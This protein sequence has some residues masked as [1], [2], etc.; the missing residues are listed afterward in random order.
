MFLSLGEWE[1]YSWKFLSSTTSSFLLYMNIL[2][3]IFF[4]I[5]SFY[6]LNHNALG[7]ESFSR[8]S[9]KTSL[10][11]VSKLWSSKVK[12]NY[13]YFRH[14]L[15]SRIVRF[16]IKIF[17]AM[18]FKWFHE[19]HPTVVSLPSKHSLAVIFVAK[20]WF[21]KRYQSAKNMV[22]ILLL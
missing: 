16:I 15:C 7:Y 12:N 21:N 18:M 4:T 10:I 20:L 1:Y 9:K 11:P 6:W 22:T 17:T 13:L 3:F 19:N 5:F 14:F 2:Y 8:K